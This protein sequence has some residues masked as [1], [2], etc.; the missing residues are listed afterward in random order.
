MRALTVVQ[1]GIGM[2]IAHGL[3]SHGKT[4]GRT[5]LVLALLGHLGNG[6]IAA[7]IAVRIDEMDPMAGHP[8]EVVLQI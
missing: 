1:T 5:S 7:R 8:I 4:K 2:A 6:R 3:D